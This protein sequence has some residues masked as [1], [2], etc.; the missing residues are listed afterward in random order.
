MTINISIEARMTSSRLPGK[1]LKL[2]NGKPSLEIML[3]RLKKV[4]LVDNIIVSTTINQEDDSIVDLCKKKNIKY[5]RGSENNVYDRVLK[6]HQQFSTDIVVEL[7]GDCILLDSELVDM[8][9]QRYLDN[10][11]EYISLSAPAGMSVQVY[12]L[13]VLESV[14]NGRELQYQDREHVTPYIYTSGK[15]N[16]SNTEAYKNLNCPDIFL[17]LD[18]IEDWQVLENIC[19]NFND[20]DFSFEDIVTFAKNNL[21]KVNLNRQVSRKGLS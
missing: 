16:I 13:K 6:T 7:T 8:A 3:D 18:T 5:F 21:D 15:Y 9:V 4:K 19:K 10:K 20:F 11:Y 2:I 14:S 17:S 1:T 12:S